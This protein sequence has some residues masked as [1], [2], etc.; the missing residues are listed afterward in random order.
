MSTALLASAKTK[1]GLASSNIETALTGFARAP[2]EKRCSAGH[3]VH[4]G[5]A[6]ITQGWNPAAPGFVTSH[7]RTKDF[8]V[9]EKAIGSLGM[10]PCVFNE[11]ESFDGR[12]YR[13]PGYDVIP[14]VPSNDL[15]TNAI[16][17]SQTGSAPWQQEAGVPPTPREC[18]ALL[19]HDGFLYQFLGV[20]YNEYNY[21]TYVMP[22]DAWRY[23]AVAGWQ[24]RSA[25]LGIERR[26]FGYVSWNGA[27][28][29]IGGADDLGTPGNPNY[30]TA[31]SEIWKSTDGM[32]SIQL[33]GNGP[34]GTVFGH[35]AAKFQ[36]HVVIV[37]GM[38]NSGTFSG[39]SVFTNKMWASNDAGLAPESWFECAPLP[40]AV[41]HAAVLV[42]T[43]DG[44]ETLAVIGGYN[45]QTH[46]A[47]GPLGT[48]Y[49]TASL[50]GPWVARYDSDFWEL[51]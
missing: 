15:T 4:Q 11:A 47:G 32:Q 31:Y 38:T 10:T 26:S 51:R 39:P 19:N 42:L 13:G 46:S 21:P 29:I 23:S 18:A 5:Y 33:V 49:T 48:I 40:I 1:I 37:G 27:I 8:I 7:Y 14:A 16:Y 30:R 28:Y 3:C 2:F 22:A 43:I 45:N 17:S 9:A 12:I 20:R 36:G 34:F 25:N 6:H 24:Q 35:R 50:N 41:A 44:V